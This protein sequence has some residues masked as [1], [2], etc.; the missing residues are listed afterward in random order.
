MIGLSF[1]SGGIVDKPLSWVIRNL[2]DLGYDGIEIVC[3]PQAH[4]RP[5]E[6]TESQLQIH[7]E[8]LDRAGLQCVAINPYTVKPLVEMERDGGARAFYEQ[9]IDLA[10]ALGAPTVNFLPGRF[11][12]GDAE[13]WRQL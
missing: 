11:P 9:L 5:A 3:G 6:A 2:G 4:I 10:V 13:A 8:E 7:R 12:G 1:H